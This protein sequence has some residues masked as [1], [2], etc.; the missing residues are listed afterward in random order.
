[1]AISPGKG[2][3]NYFLQLSPQ[4][5]AAL[6]AAAVS[7]LTVVVAT[8]LRY[9]IDKRALRYRL[10]TEYEYEQRKKLQTLIG[11]YHGRM[12]EAAESLNHRLW[13]IYEN[14]AKGWLD[15]SGHYGDLDSSYYFRTTVYRFLH[16]FSLSRMFEREA[17]YIDSR[18][19]AEKDLNFLKYL[20]A[21]EWV[22]TDVALFEGLEYDP[23][24]S[25]DHLF[26]D[27]LREMCDTCCP[28]RQFLSLEEFRGFLKG[29]HRLSPALQLFDG[30]SADEARLRWDRIVALHLVL[31]AFINT[32]GY[33][34]Q[35]ST[36]Q[37]FEEVAARLNNTQVGYN[38]KKWI[39]SLGLAKQ[40]EAK[41]IIWA[42]DSL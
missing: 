4:V 36:R 13:N 29:G 41:L 32:F 20:K 37:Q 14:E 30:L 12:L 19:T 31:L 10:K 23:F 7:L 39:P 1:L 21:L 2:V 16:L 9:A 8:P 35:R 33:D 22:V 5:Q 42:V 15:L 3:F 26:R 11:L 28:K 38:L 6:I 25:T 34:M 18:I 17:I 24:H 27:Q 40:R